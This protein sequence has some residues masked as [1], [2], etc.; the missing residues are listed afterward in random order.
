MARLK[1]IDCERSIRGAQDCPVGFFFG[2]VGEHL[3]T[4]DRRSSGVLD[5]SMYLALRLYN[6]GN[7]QQQHY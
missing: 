4:C 1:V 7:G 3:S 6:R 5:H 2:I